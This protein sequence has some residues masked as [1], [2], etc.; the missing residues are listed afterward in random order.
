MLLSELE[1]AAQDS[2]NA[3]KGIPEAALDLIEGYKIVQAQ[4]QGM[5]FFC[6]H[7]YHSLRR[8]NAPDLQKSRRRCG[9]S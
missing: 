3:A 1:K 7:G 2:V 6:F 4:S 5:I 9:A 8:G